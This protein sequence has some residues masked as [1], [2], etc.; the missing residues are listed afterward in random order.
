MS[1]RLL[2]TAELHH[3]IALRPQPDEKGHL[4]TCRSWRCAWDRIQKVE[5]L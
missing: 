4:P 3:I 1:E 5:A 2:T